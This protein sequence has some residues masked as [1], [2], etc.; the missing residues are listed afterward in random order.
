M[1]FYI[2]ILI[3]VLSYFFGF[4]N[5]IIE[6][7]AMQYASMSREILRNENFLFLFDNNTPYLDKP[8]LIFWIT[9]I[10][11]KFFGASNFT[12]RLPSFI[13]ILISIYSTYKLSYL[14]YSRRISI[15]SVLILSSSLTW[16]VMSTD[17]KTDIYMISPMM[18]GLWQLIQF[19]KTKSNMNLIIG[20]IA[21]GFSMMG[22]GPLGLVIPVFIIFIHLIHTN[23]LNRISDKVNLMGILFLLL[24]LLPMS[25]GLYKQFGFNGI[26]FYYWTQSFGRITG[27]SS[28]SNNTG[29]FYLFN[30][31][32]YSFLP[33]TFLFL[34]AFYNKFKLFI[35]FDKKD[36]RELISFSGFL[37]PLLI[38]SLSN[39]KLPHYIYCVMP[40]ASILTAQ[41]LESLLFSNKYKTV[42]FLQIATISILLIF[43]SFLTVLILPSKKIMIILSMILFFGSATTLILLKD[44]FHRFFILSITGTFILSF[45][46]NV[47]ILKPI[48]SYQAESEAAR[49]LV[50]NSYDGSPIILF[51]QNKGAKSRSFNF[52]LNTNTTYIND[53]KILN[54][55]CKFNNTFIF[56][57]E[58]GYK[59]IIDNLDKVK[60]LKVFE[61]F[62]ISKVNL[63]F[64]NHATREDVVQKKYL[65][66]V[67]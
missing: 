28:W 42:L 40:F 2:L 44:E 56:T 18:L 52:Y 13:F 39:Y 33:W 20:S 47:G 37:I 17:V 15:F 4:F 62:R 12:Y 24:A 50:N 36:H 57:N 1:V 14:F 63:K 31:F 9:S 66:K 25:V 49:Y 58:D 41:R 11:F 22:K 8:P 27:E 32:L 30:V 46:I 45:I 35:N 21:I 67:G 54:E 61:H 53:F 10:F 60:L 23:E 26:K 19:L 65:I 6:I 29:P 55:K 5:N 48:L 59:Q 51:K 16:I 64:L 43:T 3:T 7:D 38:L 34:E